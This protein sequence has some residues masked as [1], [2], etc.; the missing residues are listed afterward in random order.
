MNKYKI[1]Y[2]VQTSKGRKRK[3][4][5]FNGWHVNEAIQEC[6]ECYKLEEGYRIEEVYK[7]MPTTWDRIVID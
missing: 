2:S 1:I 4:D 3:S 5:I 7:E 6:N